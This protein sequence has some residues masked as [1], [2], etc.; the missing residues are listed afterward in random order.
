MRKI[1]EELWQGN[2][3]PQ[4]RQ[5][6]RGTHYEE[7]LKMMCKNEEKLNNML[8]GK[9]KEIFEK[10]CGCRDEVDKYTEEDI[11]VTG[12]RLGARIIVESFYENDG[13][14]SEIDA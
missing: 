6:N 12:F 7:A 3:A 11:F 14:F 10:F 8:E 1:L 2:V 4:T 13:L 9:E 5:F